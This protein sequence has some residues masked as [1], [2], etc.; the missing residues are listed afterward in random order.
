MAGTLPQ[1]SAAGLK[2]R[3]NDSGRGSAY[4]AAAAT[5]ASLPI[6]KLT[7]SSEKEVGSR[8]IFR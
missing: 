2:S 5:P 4:P 7:F 3:M 1:P 8:H 6:V